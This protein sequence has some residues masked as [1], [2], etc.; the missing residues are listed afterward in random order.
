MAKTKIPPDPG[1]TRSHTDREIFVFATLEPSMAAYHLAFD[2]EDN[3][4]V[5]G[6]TT[7]SSQIIHRISRDG[8]VAPFFKGLGRAQGMAFS[9]SG[10]LFIAASWRSHRGLIRLPPAAEPSLALSGS[11]L[12]G[13]AF[14]DDGCAA[15]ATR[16]ALFHVD[17]ETEGRPLV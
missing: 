7:S 11:N 5:A 8:T 15:L 17:L 6:P 12:V 13:L 14:L 10:D 1:A 4:F 3:L 2:K 16:D 9:K